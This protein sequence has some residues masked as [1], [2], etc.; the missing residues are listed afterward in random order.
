MVG[1]PTVQSNL[2]LPEDIH[3]WL[4]RAAARDGVSRNQKIVNLCA[5]AMRHEACKETHNA[6]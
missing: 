3:N 5:S 1:T 2:R 6:H 4:I